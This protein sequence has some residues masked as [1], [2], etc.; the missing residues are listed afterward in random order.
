MSPVFLSSG[1]SITSTPFSLI[2]QVIPPALMLILPLVSAVLLAHSPFSRIKLV[3]NILLALNT[4][5]PAIASGLGLGVSLGQ[6]QFL[7]HYWNIS[8]DLACV[9]PHHAR[10]PGSPPRRSLRSGSCDDIPH[11]RLNS[12]T[13]T[14]AG[15]IAST[16]TLLSPT[17]SLVSRSLQLPLV[18]GIF[19]DIR[20]AI[21]LATP[22]TKICEKSRAGPERSDHP[23][24]CSNSSRR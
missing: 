17:F 11:L 23:T 13:A 10:F 18:I 9:S 19:H 22:F 8:L 24:I 14:I 3:S 5:L 15:S 12:V 6:A 7:Q 20:S 21:A 4:V 2:L 1:S 16:P